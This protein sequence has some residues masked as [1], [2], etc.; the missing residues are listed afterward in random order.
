MAE[1]K[2]VIFKLNK[3]EY[4]VDIMM[5]KEVSEVRETIKVPNTPHFVDGIINIRGEITPI[6][7]LKK[8]F[9]IEDNRESIEGAKII[10]VSIKDKLVGFLVDDVSQVLSIDEENIDPAPGLIVDVDKAYIQGISKL[11]DKMII[12]LD[13][14]KVL[15]ENEKDLIGEMDI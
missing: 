4:G 1:K 8:R 12:M 3:E 6:I 11:E 13:L 10:V 14:E 5:V 15:D 2:Y 9:N 7:S